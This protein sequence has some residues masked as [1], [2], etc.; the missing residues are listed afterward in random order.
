M[1]NLASNFKDRVQ[2]SVAI[3]QRQ[4][5]FDTLRQFVSYKGTVGDLIKEFTSAGMWD[6][7][8]SISFGDFARE[9]AV[10]A[11]GAP[12]E[13]TK[14]T[15]KKRVARKPKAEATAAT[16]TTEV[17]KVVKPRKTKE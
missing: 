9:L 16:D 10:A 2:E 4:A 13:V 5:V 8:S 12:A 17:V 11:S 14:K 7:V 3:A 1:A 6:H 15:R